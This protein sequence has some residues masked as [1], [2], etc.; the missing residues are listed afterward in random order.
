[1]KTKLLKKKDIIETFDK[2]FTDVSEAGI[3][4]DNHLITGVCLFGTKESK[5]DRKY[6][7]RAVDSLV[8]LAEGC[9]SFINHSTKE[10]QKNRGGVRDLRDWAGCFEGARRDGDKVLANFR[11]R[12]AYWDL[13]SDIA[14]MGP[15]NVGLSIDA[16]VKVHQSE[17]G[18]ENVA[19]VVK[20]RGCDLVASAATTQNLFESAREKA[21]KDLDN[22][23]SL[24]AYES[25]VPMTIEDKFK[26]LSVEEGII[27][28]KIDNDKLKYEISDVTYMANDLI[29]EV[30]Y[31]SDL[32]VEDK[33]KKVM[34]IFSDLDK[35]IRKRLSKL[36]K[37][38]E[39]DLQEMD[40]TLEMVKENKEIMEAI[41]QEL[42]DKLAVDKTLE[43]VTALETEIEDL[44]KAVTENDASIKE[45]DEKITALESEKQGLELKLDE[46]EVVE[47]K[48]KK[49]ALVESLISDSELDKDSVTDVFR[50]MVMKVEEEKDGDKVTKTVEEGVKALI[51]DRIAVVK[52]SNKPAGKVIGSGDEYVAASESDENK[53]G[54]ELTKDTLEEAK[55]KFV[56]NLKD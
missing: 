22:D 4:E 31:K 45:K 44:K 28:D 56:F 27:Q 33:K 11:V 23:E 7:D 36:K 35:E 53:K 9:K 34:N 5:N 8:A 38:V 17:D 47:R 24:S 6:S 18:M 50:E 46:I 16:M 21:E 12:E 41:H 30:I 2:P 13:L 1:M 40:I 10:E 52:K 37:D 29:R 48:N 14:V 42:K 54:D 55:D 25:I 51:D 19:D 3:D 20:L 39:E 15:K 32:S 43:K 49:V 26:Y